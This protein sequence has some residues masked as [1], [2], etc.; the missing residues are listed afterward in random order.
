MEKQLS[1]FDEDTSSQEDGT[2]DQGELSSQRYEK[3]VVWAIALIALFIAVLKPLG[4]I[5]SM[6]V[7]ML[8]LLWKFNPRQIKLNVLYSVLFPLGIYLLFEVW[9]RAGLP[10]G[11]L[12]Y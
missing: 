10:D 12:S 5:L 11:I 1:K 6:V 9:L 8:I 4:A 7:F 3:D 2:N